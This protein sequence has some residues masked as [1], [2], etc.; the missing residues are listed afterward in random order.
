VRNI[1]T[2]DLYEASYYLSNHCQIETIETLAIDG[3]ISCQLT[4]AGEKIHTL[5]AAYFAG[6]AQIRLFDFRRTYGQ[7]HKVVNDAKKKYKQQIRGGLK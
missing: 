3:R 6:E 5:Q 7:L 4:I 1:Q 2:S